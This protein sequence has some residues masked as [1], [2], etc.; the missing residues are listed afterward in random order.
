MEDSKDSGSIHTK[1][2]KMGNGNMHSFR[3]IKSRGSSCDIVN[4]YFII[5]VIKS[6]QMFLKI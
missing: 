3:G 6:L 4:V 5:N 2:A 1:E